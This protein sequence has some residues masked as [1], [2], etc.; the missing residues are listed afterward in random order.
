ML[1]YFFLLSGGCDGGSGDVAGKDRVCEFVKPPK[2]AIFHN[3]S[4]DFPDF[5]M[6]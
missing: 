4:V 1:F 6:T 3:F 2:V 5:L